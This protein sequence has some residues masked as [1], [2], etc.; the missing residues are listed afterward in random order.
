[1]TKMYR[2]KKIE[3]K[4]HRSTI[5]NIDLVDSLEPMHRSG[6]LNQPY[7]PNSNISVDSSVERH[8]SS[9]FDSAEKTILGESS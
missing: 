7:H 6:T 1:M 8:P 5:E 2:E 4:L 9:L 3:K